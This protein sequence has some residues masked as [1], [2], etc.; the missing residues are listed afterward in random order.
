[1]ADRNFD[2]IVDKFAKYL[3]NDKRKIREAVVWQDLTQLLSSQ[4]EG[5]TLKILDAGGGEGH[6]SRKLAEMGHQVI[7]CDLSEEMLERGSELAKE[8]GISD[9]MRFVHCAV[10]DIAQYI[11]EPVDLVLFHG[12]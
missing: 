6:F 1:M 9:N 10:Q 3:R 4:F 2:D 8:Q 12:T 5:K 11:D 7:L